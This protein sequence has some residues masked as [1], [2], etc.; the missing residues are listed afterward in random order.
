MLAKMW[1]MEYTFTPSMIYAIRTQEIKS[2]DRV[3]EPSVQA[4]TLAPET[5]LQSESLQ[6]VESTYK[7]T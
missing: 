6:T 4:E 3:E 2:T 5:P 1:K 7:S